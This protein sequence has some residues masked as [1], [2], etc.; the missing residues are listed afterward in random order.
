MFFYPKWSVDP[1]ALGAWIFPLALLALIG[2]LAWKHRRWGSGPL[3]AALFFVGTLFP[4]LGFV[5][6]YPMRYSFVAD[7]FQYLASIGMIGLVAAGLARWEKQALL[8]PLVL[9]ALTFNRAAVFASPE[10]LWNDTLG[11]NPSAWAAHDQLAAMY[12]NQAAQARAQGQL[13]RAA[14]LFAQAAG[15]LSLSIQINPAHAEAYI[16][17]GQLL[18]QQGDHPGAVAQMRNAVQV[19]PDKVLPRYGLGVA[20]LAADQPREA[21]EVLEQAVGLKPSFAPARLRLADAYERLGQSD[22]AAM[23]RR[24]AQRLLRE[25]FGYDPA[26]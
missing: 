14:D 15:H 13:D 10:A 7:H 17:L 4:A 8:V 5:N 9:A 20:L 19:Q 12:T 21:A 11:K 26:P 2:L 1:G 23:Q 18:L 22:N 3:V 25:A 16:G 24:E 6:V